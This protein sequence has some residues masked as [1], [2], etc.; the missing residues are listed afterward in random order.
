MDINELKEIVKLIKDNNLS[1]L[2]LKN[3]EEYVKI[4]LQ[5]VHSI[6]NAVKIQG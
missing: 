6:E 3:G 2:E 4:E 5:Q 1:L